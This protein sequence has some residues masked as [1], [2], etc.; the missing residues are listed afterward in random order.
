[1]Q[2]PSISVGLCPKEVWNSS[3]MIY[4]TGREHVQPETITVKYGKLITLFPHK[5]I[6]VRTAVE[7]LLRSRQ[8]QC[9]CLK[10]EFSAALA[11]VS[12]SALSTLL[13]QMLL[14]HQGRFKCFCRI[15]A[16]LVRFVK[17]TNPPCTKNAYGRTQKKCNRHIRAEK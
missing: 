14:S 6:Y 8:V 1:M 10:K 2:Y 16:L 15:T 5:K 11:T 13:Y 12:P 7:I 4:S 17:C 9:L 3:E